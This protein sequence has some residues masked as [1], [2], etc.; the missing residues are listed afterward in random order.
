M[1][2]YLQSISTD[3]PEN[4]YSQVE[5]REKMKELVATSDR[6]RKI[7]HQIYSS[8]GIAKRHSV[9]NDFREGGTQELYYNGHGASPA[10]GI[11]NKLYEKKGREMF[12]RAARKALVESSSSPES[13]THLITISCTGFY[14]PG[15]DFDIIKELGLN[16]D[17]ER[18]NLGFMGCY[19]AVPGLKMASV[20]CNSHEQAKVLIVSS[21]LCTLHFQGGAS[22]DELISSSVFADGAAATIVTAKK[23]ASGSYIR[24]GKFASVITD[25][26]AGDMAW[27]IGDT[28]FK[29]VLS[30]Y[31]PEI[32]SASLDKF[33]NPL[34]E[35]YLLEKKQID[36]WAV[37][38]GGRAILDRIEKKLAL[39]ADIMKYSRK[40]LSDYG[41]MSSATLLFVIK[42]ILDELSP[43]SEKN[44]LAL[45]FGPGLTIE[46]ALLHKKT[47]SG[48]S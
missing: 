10:T 20:I 3:V 26:G 13:I 37:H 45:A 48:D 46:S 1:A 33:L 23:P 14:A 22:I 40:V 34:L 31:I 44:I 16:L 27:T 25:E 29:M 21:E 42:E 2:A 19:A 12:V 35:K 28:G 18:Y 5:L 36:R 41:N 43:A 9:L 32:L 7:I 24:I 4:V 47:P 6:H 8:S 17:I 11:R 30:A 15:P 38:P 39:P